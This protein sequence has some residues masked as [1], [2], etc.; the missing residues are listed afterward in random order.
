MQVE[1]TK[2]GMLVHARVRNSRSPAI[3][4][5]KRTAAITGIVVHQTDANTAQSSLNSYRNPKANGAHFLID[6]DGTI[7]Q[8]AAIYQRANH[9]GPLKARCLL[10]VKCKAKDYEGLKAKGVHRI[11]MMKAPGERYPS[12]MEAIGIEMVGRAE[13]PKGIKLSPREQNF[14]PEKLRGERGVY[15][16]PTEAQNRSL[17][18]LVEV[19]QFSMELAPSEVFKHPK[20]SQKNPTEAEGANWNIPIEKP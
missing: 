17:T 16:T 8:T 10:V 4:R 1:I 9:V 11:E 20:V 12:N 18:W 6:K 7:Y 5:G 15:P 2:D 13:L 14:S 19:L 3:E